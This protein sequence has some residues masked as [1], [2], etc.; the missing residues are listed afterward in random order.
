[1]V[2]VSL[3]LRGGSSQFLDLEEKYLQTKLLEGEKGEKIREGEGWTSC[4]V[5]KR[6]GRGFPGPGKGV[7]RG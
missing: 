1:M 5:V 6:I 3:L 2:L 4:K 7:K